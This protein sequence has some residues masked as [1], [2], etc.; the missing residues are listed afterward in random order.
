[1]S[2]DGARPWHRP[3]FQIRAAR[4]GEWPAPGCTGVFKFLKRLVTPAPPP[5]SHRKP[6]KQEPKRKRSRDELLAAPVSTFDVVE[7]NSEQDWALWED[8]V[9]MMDSQAQPLA[10][11]ANGH[12]KPPAGASGH[13]DAFSRVRKRDR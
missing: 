6:R 9:A 7:G 11:R 10:P 13:A 5:L 1:M 8:S 4:R 2:K 3:H 12:D